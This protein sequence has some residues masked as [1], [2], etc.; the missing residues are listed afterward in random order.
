VDVLNAQ[1][2]LA[3]TRLG[4]S[5]ADTTYREGLLRIYAAAGR[6]FDL[7]GMGALT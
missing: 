6:A 4:A 3:E 1:R 2:D 7:L 5:R